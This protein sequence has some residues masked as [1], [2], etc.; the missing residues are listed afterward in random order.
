MD[1]GQAQR[2]SVTGVLYKQLTS[3]ILQLVIGTALVTAILLRKH[4]YPSEGR[5]AWRIGHGVDKT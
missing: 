5:W 1:D 3:S 2:M 4:V